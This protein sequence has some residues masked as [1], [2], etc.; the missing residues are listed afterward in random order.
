MASRLTSQVIV[1]LVA[2]L[3]ALIVAGTLL[4]A[5]GSDE[6]RGAAPAA[7]GS[8]R[9]TAASDPEQAGG[10][11]HHDTPAA[12][13]RSKPLRRGETRTTLTMQEPYTPSAP[14]G[15]GTDDYRCFLL[16]PQL[17]EDAFLTGTHVLPGNP[18]VVHHVIL[19]RVPPEQVAE[20]RQADAAEAG[21]GWTCFGGTG[22]DDFTDVDDAEWLGAWA[23]GGRE[24]VLRRGLGVPLD[25]GA[26]IVMQVHYNLLAGDEP[27]VSATQLR[28]APRGA[29]LAA[30]HTMLL[31][32]PVELPCRRGHDDSPLCDRATALADVKA[33][34]GDRAGSTADILY[35]LCGGA[36]TPGNSQSCTRTL[37]APATIHGVAGHMH[38]LGRSITVEVNAGTPQARTVLDIPVWN[39]DNQGA[40]PIEPVRLAAGDQVTVTC[41]HVQWLR[42]ELPSFE[43]QE[44]RYVVWGEGTTDE[45][46]LGLLQLT[47]P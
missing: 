3:L 13:V 12:A 45:M 37:M 30:L 2:T 11:G 23:P 1:R 39:F 24:S 28:L 8:D 4:A 15:V 17:R 21:P 46:C 18:D 9:Q 14:T 31:P 27:D 10:S 33:R 47:H 42:D 29:E 22:L 34:F 43:G 16:D 19:F 41:R 26:Q 20:A 5:C 36:P 32:A 40:T 7:P 38:L 44:E 6:Q 35:F 25:K